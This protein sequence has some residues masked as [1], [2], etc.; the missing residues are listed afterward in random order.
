MFAYFRNETRVRRIAPERGKDRYMRKRSVRSIGLLRL[1]GEEP[2]C[3]KMRI[4]ARFFQGSDDRAAAIERT[5]DR[6][7]FV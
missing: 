6:S 2:A 5:H 1:G 3:A 4:V 7:P